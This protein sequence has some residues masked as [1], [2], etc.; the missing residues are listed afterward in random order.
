MLY[1]MIPHVNGSELG[2]YLIL[3]PKGILESGIVQLKKDTGEIL[4]YLTKVG[5]ESKLHLGTV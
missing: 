3:Q 4:R 1:K 5:W 2:H